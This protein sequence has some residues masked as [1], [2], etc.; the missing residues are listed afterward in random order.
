MWDIVFDIIAAQ[1]NK[2]TATKEELLE[3]ELQILG[4]GDQ[5]AERRAEVEEELKLARQQRAEKERIQNQ[6]DAADNAQSVVDVILGQ[7]AESPSGRGALSDSD[8]ILKQQLT[9]VEADLVRHGELTVQGSEA[10][11]ATAKDDLRTLAEQ[12]E[13]LEEGIGGG[14]AATKT[15]PMSLATGEEGEGEGEGGGGGEGGGER[16][17]ERE[18][19]RERGRRSSLTE[20]M[21][22]AM[23]LPEAKDNTRVARMIRRRS[24]A[25][26]VDIAAA[27]VFIIFLFHCITEYLTNVMIFVMIILF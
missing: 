1:S 6:D 23:T 16:E 14:S 10:V 5:N 24:I 22:A 11:D 21:Q 4:D 13:E 19:E 26:E 15:A 27:Q 12:E 8:K 25:I 18:R 17:G 3:K 20:D 7:G 2:N 9:D